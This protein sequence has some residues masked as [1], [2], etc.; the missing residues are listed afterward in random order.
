MTMKVT[1]EVLG[2]FARQQHDLFERVRKGALD[3]EKVYQAVKPLLKQ[4]RR[5]K[6]PTPILRLLTPDLII[7]ATDGTENLSDAVVF[8][9]YV[10]PDL[11]RWGC[12]VVS[13]A[14]PETPVAVH[15]LCDNGTFQQIFGGQG[16]DLDQLCLTP[17][18]I[19]QFVRT[20]PEHLHPE[21]YATFFLFKVAGK[22]FVAGIYWRAACRLE[23]RV[24]RLSHDD[25]WYADGRYRVVLPQLAL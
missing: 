19:K 9:G 10:D 20:Y 14:K 24:R 1:D 8:P 25:V 2:R 18:Q 3:P 17:H 16:V 4:G 23:V 22:F 7:P 15:D 11:K 13:K 12:N 6:T 5:V 21:G